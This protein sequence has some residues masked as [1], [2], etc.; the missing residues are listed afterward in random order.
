MRLL[1]IVLT[2]YAL[3]VK[4]ASKPS[5][6]HSGLQA[7]DT[8]IANGDIGLQLARELWIVRHCKR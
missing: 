7:L 1:Q 2:T 8:E 5:S 3:Y 6:V 4:N